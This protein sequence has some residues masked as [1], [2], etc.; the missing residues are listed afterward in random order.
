MWFLF[1]SAIVLAVVQSNVSWQW[2]DHG[3]QVGIVGVGLAYLATLIVSQP[4]IRREDKTVLPMTATRKTVVLI[5]G[6][7]AVATQAWGWEPNPPRPP[8][9]IPNVPRLAALM[10]PGAPLLRSTP[11]PIPPA[12]PITLKPLE[13]PTPPQ[14]PTTAMMPVPMPPQPGPA[15]LTPAMMP[16]GSPAIIPSHIPLPPVEFDHEYVGRLTVLKEPTYNLIRH[17]CSNTANAIACSY[18]TY[19]SATG[20]NISCLVMLGPDVHENEQVLKHEIGHCNGWSNEH[21]GARYD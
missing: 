12:E 6:I 8:L 10:P 11:T 2:A 15:W 14:R 7:L 17:V 18:R 5:A 13:I 19:D 4:V 21:E 9:P 20:A 1:Q 3:I 16:P